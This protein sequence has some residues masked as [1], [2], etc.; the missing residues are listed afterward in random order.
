MSFKDTLRKF[1]YFC[2]SITLILVMSRN[3][4]EFQ[5]KTSFATSQQSQDGNSR[6]NSV[7]CNQYKT[8]IVFSA[9]LFP[10]ITVC[11][12]TPDKPLGHESV[13]DI[14]A[15]LGNDRFVSLHHSYMNS[16]SGHKVMI[17]INSSNAQRY[18]HMIYPRTVYH[19]MTLSLVACTTYDPSDKSPIG[20]VDRVKKRGE[21]TCLFKR[22]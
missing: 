8:V 16:S 7:W 5:R 14:M 6:F 1:L 2:L 4:R 3:M 22:A 21:L 12:I 13:D 20:F 17:N 11:P 15:E 18:K 10:S 19:F 9:L